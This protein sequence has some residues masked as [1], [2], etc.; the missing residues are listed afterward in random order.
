MKKQ[1]KNIWLI[2]I[3]GI[4][5]GF[6]MGLW[7]GSQF[8]PRLQTTQLSDLSGEQQD[9][10][11]GLVALGYDATGDFDNAVQQ[12]NHLNAPNLELLVSGVLER[13]ARQGRTPQQLSALAQLALKL[14]APQATLARYLPTPTPLPT[15]PPTLVPPTPTLAPA[16]TQPPAQSAAPATATPMEAAE[17]ATATATSQPAAAPTDIP[18]AT[19]EPKPM[20]VAGK[21]INVRGGPGTDYAVVGSLDNGDNVRIVAKNNA[22]DWWQIRLPNEVLGWVY[23]A[24]VSI[25]G[26]TAGVPIAANI[27]APP[28]TST[29]AAPP[30]PPQPAGPDIRLIR[31]RLLTV[32]EN[33]GSFDGTSIHCGGKHDLRVTVVDAAGNP[34]NGVTVRSIYTNEEH[35]TGEKGPGL[36]EFNLYPPGNGVSVVRDV[37]GRDVNS[38]SAE[39]PTVVQ[40]IPISELIAGGYCTNQQDCTQKIASN[41]LCHGHYSWDVTFQRTY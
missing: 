3:I 26:D 34:L 10:Y 24:I 29:P 32:Q 23:N 8:L 38:D 17:A 1:K 33:E 9:Q 25:T 22:G 35:V 12:L 30:T 41:A 37:D 28:A 21:T 15:A 4:I 31:H 39:A 13:A 20:V 6:L 36:V 27:P 19:P 18:T 7:A 2:A 11:V 14:G 5:A 40:S 16:A